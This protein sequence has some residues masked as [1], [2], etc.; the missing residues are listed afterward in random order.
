MGQISIF[1]SVLQQ[2]D[3]D[4]GMHMLYLE[5]SS[6]LIESK[7]PLRVILLKDVNQEL[8][9]DPITN[10][11]PLLSLPKCVQNSRPIFITAFICDSSV[12]MGLKVTAS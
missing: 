9:N 1:F 5:A 3:V 4:I 2:R 8:R 7:N 10:P 6:L 11:P 12:E